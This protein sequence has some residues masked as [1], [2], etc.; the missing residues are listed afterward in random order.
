MPPVQ[1]KAPLLPPLATKT[2]LAR[3]L[4]GSRGRPWRG[5]RSRPRKL[6]R[7][8]EPARRP[9]KSQDRP[10][11]A[12]PV[13]CCGPGSGPARSGWTGGTT[14][15]AIFAWS[16]TG[17]EPRSVTLVRRSKRWAGRP[18]RIS[19]QAGTACP[20]RRHQSR[21]RCR[22]LRARACSR[23]RRLPAYRPRAAWC[24]CSRRITNRSPGQ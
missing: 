21:T 12:G 14:C 4:P 16:P 22:R 7:T 19:A 8:N 17:A 6:N 9:Q 18:G 20:F 13:S 11:L 5:G 2:E 1:V 10:S 15:D 23:P 24:T 3:R